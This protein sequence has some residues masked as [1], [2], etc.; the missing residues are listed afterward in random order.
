MLLQKALFN[1]D[2]ADFLERAVAEKADSRP[3]VL[4][5]DCLVLVDL[6][7]ARVGVEAFEARLEIDAG[8]QGDGRLGATLKRIILLLQSNF[9]FVRLEAVIHGRDNIHELCINP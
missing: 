5:R 2:N 4:L 8:E 9:V 3:V 6:A 1:I 7:C